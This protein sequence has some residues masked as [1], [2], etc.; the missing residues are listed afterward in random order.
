M[1]RCQAR[2]QLTFV[3]IAYFGLKSTWFKRRTGMAHQPEVLVGEA[4]PMS[5][6][7]TELL[8]RLLQWPGLEVRD[9]TE[10]PTELTFDVVQKIIEN[11]IKVQQRLYGASSNLPVY[12]ETI[13][14]EL[15]DPHQLRVVMVQSL[16]PQKSDFVSAGTKLD[17]PDFR[18]RHRN[19]VA[20]LARLVFDKL[21]AVEEALSPRTS[22]PQPMAD[23]I[24]FPELAV[25]PH[26]I[27]I[28]KRLADKSRAMIFTGLVFRQQGGSLVNTS[29]GQ[30]H[31][32]MRC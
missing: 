31:E 11:R 4:A 28:L 22:K 3:F 18:P 30:S 17:S 10:W 27:V 25:H 1:I 21:A 16:L 2:I 26:D 29:P 15:K 32:I 14:H 13:D 23:L 8:Y 5:S 7:V 19:H 6:W 24:V 20:R 9:K 12:V